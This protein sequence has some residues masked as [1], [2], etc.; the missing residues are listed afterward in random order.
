MK[1][2]LDYTFNF[3]EN[4]IS[5]ICFALNSMDEDCGF[6]T[7]IGEVT[8]KQIKSADCSQLKLTNN[9]FEN[10]KLATEE[11]RSQIEDALCQ[12]NVE[13][14]RETILED[15]RLVNSVLR[16]LRKSTL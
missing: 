12:L 14:S 11:L 8:A 6:L 10:I 5:I 1:N 15:Q 2:T 9:Q 4:E 16:K 3:T 13:K 7:N